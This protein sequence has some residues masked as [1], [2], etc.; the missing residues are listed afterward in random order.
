MSERPVLALQ[1]FWNDITH[2]KICRPKRSRGGFGVASKFGWGMRNPND[3]IWGFWTTDNR[4][5]QVAIAVSTLLARVRR[6]LDIVYEDS[7]Y[8]VANGHYQHVYYWNQTDI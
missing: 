4:T 3:T 2:N 7:A 5:L 8:P 6:Q 1:S